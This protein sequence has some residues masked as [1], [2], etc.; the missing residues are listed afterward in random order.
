MVRQTGVSED[1]KHPWKR[2]AWLHY[3]CKRFI[4]LRGA[5]WCRMSWY[6]LLKMCAFYLRYRK[7]VQSLRL[8]MT[9]RH[10]IIS[11]S[12]K[13][14]LLNEQY[15]G[16]TSMKSSAFESSI[17]RRNGLFINIY[18]HIWLSKRQRIIKNASLRILNSQANCGSGDILPKLSG[19]EGASGILSY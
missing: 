1:D 7:K 5:Y 2:K 10:T 4:D 15:N 3:Y 6:K 9:V 8:P 11:L 12:R 18:H 17:L 14:N 16:D 13:Q 19:N